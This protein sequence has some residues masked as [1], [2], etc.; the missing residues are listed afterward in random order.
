MLMLACGLLLGL[1]HWRIDEKR[2]DDSLVIGAACVEERASIMLSLPCSSMKS[3]RSAEVSQKRSQFLT[4]ILAH[5]GAHQWATIRQPDRWW[6]HRVLA[7][8]TE[9][10]GIHRLLQRIG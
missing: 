4:T 3:L 5:D 7:I 1:V 9:H 10:T 8:P 6:N 2:Q